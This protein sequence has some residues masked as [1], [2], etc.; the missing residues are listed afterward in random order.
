MTATGD[1]ASFL[2]LVAGVE[3]RGDYDAFNLGGSKGGH[4]PH[5]SGFGDAAT[6][7]WGRQLT[8]MTVGEIM[9][10]GASPS[11]ENR[12]VHAAGRYQIIPGTLRGLVQRYK[13]D[14]NAPFDAAMQDQLAM[15]LAYQRLVQSNKI[16]GL[17]NEWIGLNN[18]SAGQIEGSLGAAF[19]NPQLLL[20]GV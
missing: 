14:K 5:G 6:K 16:N 19:N 9:E 3:S 20:K 4:V 1:G 10:I 18:V 8:Q 7:R 13:I 17:R 11:S 2:D 15:Y 12:W